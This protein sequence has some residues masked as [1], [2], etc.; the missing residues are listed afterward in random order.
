MIMQ[1]LQPSWRCSLLLVGSVVA[2][3]GLAVALADGRWQVL[4][5]LLW[6]LLL[7]PVQVQLARGPRRAVELNGGPPS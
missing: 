5:G 4:Q 3:G 2:V 7:A 6:P 1:S